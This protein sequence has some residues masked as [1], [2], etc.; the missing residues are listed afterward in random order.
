MTE[1]QVMTPYQWYKSDESNATKT[2]GMQMEEYAKY[3]AI[4]FLD[5]ARAYER[6]SGK[7]ICYDERESEE[8]YLIFTGEKEAQ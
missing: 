1:S 2:T 7:A 3:V 5:S 4:A 6:E 8:F